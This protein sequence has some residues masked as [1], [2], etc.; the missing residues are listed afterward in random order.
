[1]THELRRYRAFARIGFYQACADRAE[2]YGRIAFLVIILGIFSALW[3]AVGAAAAPFAESPRT[4]LF[5]L[6]TTEWILLAAPQVQFEI[7]AEVRRGDMAYQLGRPVSYVGAVLAHAVGMLAAR[8]PILLA[9]SGI[10]A[11]LFAGGAPPDLWGLAYAIPLGVIGSLVLVGL[12]MVIGLAAFWLDDIAPLHW[13]VQKLTFVLGGLILPLPFYPHLLARMA[14]LTPFP[15]VLYGPASFV[16]DG[17][18]VRAVRIAFELAGWFVFILG[19]SA[20]LFRRASSALQLN[21]G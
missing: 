11:F 13:V 3:K 12:N 9:A 2:L 17:G 21:G 15:A 14:S 16:V 10:A 5:Y 18:P 8:S 1:M 20:F 6:A 7:E 19:L 4:L